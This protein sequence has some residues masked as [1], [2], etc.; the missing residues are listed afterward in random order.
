MLGD[1]LLVAPIFSASGKVDV[2]LPAGRWTHLF[3]GKTVHGGGW[4]HEQHDFMSLPLYVRP[5]TLLVLGAN[6]ERPDYDF[7]ERAELQLFALDDGAL[8]TAVVRDLAGQAVLQASAR[9]E[10]S[11]LT[12]KQQGVRGSRSLVLR[13]VP[14]AEVLSAGLKVLVTEYGVCVEIPEGCEEIELQVPAWG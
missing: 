3:S 9:R 8:A 1:S 6:A 2:Y 7:A 12:F 13:N 5:N 11:K 14:N 10:G 4:Q